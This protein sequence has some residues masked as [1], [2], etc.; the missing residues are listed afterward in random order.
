MLVIHP[1]DRTTDM[2]CALYEGVPN[3]TLM[4]EKVYSKAEVNHAL[5]HTPALERIMLLG[6]GGELGLYSRDDDSS[7]VLEFDHLL[8]AHPHA[9]NLRTHLTTIGV[10]CNANL[11]A[12]R[13]GLHGLFTGMIITELSEAAMYNIPTTQDELNRENVLFAQRLGTLL[14]NKVSLRDIPAIFR[15]TDTAHT[16][17]TEFNYNNLYYI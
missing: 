11:F 2:L 16:P 6:H 10:F 1:Q 13:E 17:L 7:D 5:H 12:K 15:D 8:V 3:V 4:R 14:R 9:Y